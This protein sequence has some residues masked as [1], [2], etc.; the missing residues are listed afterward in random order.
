LQDEF[1]KSKNNVE[2][3]FPLSNAML[4]ACDIKEP[5]ACRVKFVHGD[6]KFAI[7]NADGINQSA[8]AWRPQTTLPSIETGNSIQH[9]PSYNV[10]SQN[11]YQSRVDESIQSTT[12]TS[13]TTTTHASRTKKSVAKGSVDQK[14]LNNGQE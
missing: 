11:A 4:S 6:E 13:V 3:N 10:S 7:A 8:G 9:D 1:Q 5:E 14:V 12:T 2:K